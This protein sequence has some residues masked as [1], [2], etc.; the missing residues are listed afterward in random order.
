V[1]PGPK[2]QTPGPIDLEAEY[3]NRARCPDHPAVMA[4]WKA[5]AEAARAA[6]PPVEIA[7]GPGPR[8]RMDLFPAEEGSPV[9]VFLHGGYWQALDKSWFSGIA[10]ALLAHGI[11]L[12]VPSYDLA[13]SVRLG[14]IVDQM[15]AAVALL[16]ERTGSK[17]IMFGHS[18]GGHMAAAM[19]SE[20]RASAAV[21]IAGVFDVRPL[22]QTSLN[23][24]LGLD[25]ERAEALSPIDWPVPEGA[26]LDCVVGGAESPEFIRQSRDMAAAWGR[27]GA[28]TRFE[29]LEG[30]DHFTVLDPL[31]DADS[32]LVGRIVELTRAGR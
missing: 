16:S 12:A 15:R 28:V 31:F 32:G 17:P 13:P 8:E 10:P 18:A 24:A 20:D 23:V 25:E 19:L 9:A 7:Y 14:A 27:R 22:I 29:A 11:G 6:H 3:N 1:N 30:L 4:R 2:P 26:V 5:S 21:A